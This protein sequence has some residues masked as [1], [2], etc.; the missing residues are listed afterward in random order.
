[1]TYYLGIVLGLFALMI[2][3]DKKLRLWHTYATVS[4]LCS[5]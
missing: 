5:T 3:P 1:V 4:F 2:K